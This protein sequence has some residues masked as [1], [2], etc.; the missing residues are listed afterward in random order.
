MK[1]TKLPDAEIALIE[2][3]CPEL[4]PEYFAYL[5]DVGW[6]ETASA[7]MIYSGPISPQD[8][9]GASF[10]QPGIVLLGDDFQGHCFGYDL[11]ASTYG[12][13]SP[14]GSWHVWPSGKGIR[15][16]AGA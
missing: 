2:A 1:V 10:R 12:E 16:Y 7:R 4:P 5:R 11:I 14:D 3:T 6:G 13:A 9:Y 15:H 8:V